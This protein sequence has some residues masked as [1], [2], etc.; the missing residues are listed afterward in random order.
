VT[1]PD[2]WRRIEE[3]FTAALDLPPQQQEAYLQAACGGDA[4]LR[5]EVESL[6]ERDNGD[7]DTKQSHLISGIIEGT[8]AN[9]FDD[10][11]PPDAMVG[12][13]LGNY[14]IIREL[15]RGGMGAVYL[16]GRFDSTF[17]KQVAIKLVKRGIDTD[18]VLQ[19]F[20]YER[21]I[22]AGLEHPYIAR[23]VD[24]GTSSDGRPYFV[25]EYVDGMPLDAYV[26]A[27]ALSLAARCELF[28]KICEAVSYAHRNLI[29]HRDLK[30]AN[31]LVTADGTPKL[32]DFGI[33]RLLS[34]DPD[35]HTIAGPAGIH[36]LA[37]TPDFAS[38]EQVRGEA[39]TTATDV[40][41]LGAVLRAMLPTDAAIPHD[42]TTI[43]G[44]AMREE[45]DQRF[46]SVADLSED[47]RR[48]LAG[49]PI[50]AREQTLAYSAA[51]FI[52]RHR[53]AVG[54]FA[55][56]NLL[57]FGGIAGIVWESRR[58]DA[59]RREAEQRLSQAVEMADRTLKDVNSS[60]AS[61]PGTTEARRQM[62]RSTLEYLDGLAKDS[63]NDPRVQIALAT[64]YVRVGE[65][66]GNSDFPNL[67][68]LPQSLAT[69]HRAL[70]VI[71]P[72]V[73]TDAGN[74]RVQLLASQAHQGTAD[75][76]V[77][78]GRDNDA[79]VEFR[80]AISSADQALQQSP[81]DPELQYQSLGA[82]YAFDLH[83]YSSH[84]E[85]AEK[86]A[87]Q[88]LPLAEKLAAAQPA[89]LD[90]QDK[91]SEFYA[92]I[93]TTLNRFNRIDEALTYYR[94]ASTVREAIYRQ[95]PRNTRLQRNLMIGYGHI[96]D[97]LGNPFTGCLADY[98][99]G[100]EYFLK[101]AAIAE[102]MHRAD[103]SDRRAS[104]DT[105][106]V[107]T[108]IGAT[109]SAAGS[110][111]QSNQY[112]DRAIALFETLM[113]RSPGNAGY[114]RGVSLAYDFRAQNLWTQRDTRAALVWYRKSLAM[115]DRVLAISSS[116]LSARGQRMA[117]EG[118]VAT[119][120]AE[121]G[122]RAGAIQMVEGLVKE[123]EPLQDYRR[124]LHLARAWGWYGRVYET[125]HDYRLAEIGYAKSSEAWNRV[126]GVSS[127]PPY[128]AQLQEMTRKAAQYR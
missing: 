86:D 101:A 55:L 24:G 54:V 43:V 3:V 106:M 115:A 100:L 91:L 34:V 22:L 9:L 4:D 18:A 48:Y 69:Y 37:L 15:G 102:D 109:Q 121:T 23:L 93:G 68:D 53:F 17:D 5:L 125:L 56:A 16:A 66:L 85:E 14:R 95:N 78:M 31:V 32:L 51:K 124:E 25:M 38:P 127:V 122:D 57:V 116:D 67:G 20:W 35:E 21:R 1:P 45:V 107:W 72:L 96:G 65:V 62:V 13:E 123:A 73:I 128:L 114:L 10:E 28:R 84:P 11:S 33:A 110:L 112:L 59:Q 80:T 97:V 36:A 79:A 89:N 44:K 12:A 90:R 58:A 70:A 82:H 108:R 42:L 98:S 113:A 111:P 41:S 71:Q 99:G 50:L 26:R 88:Q 49:L 119:L 19:R 61:L 105:A 94:K 40:Y 6:L 77:S 2:R 29:I 81:D 87:R 126:P 92:I 118:P 39:I 60:I 46:A 104:F 76:L 74:V 120:L 7:A 30:P 75:I 83:R 52:R 27:Q 8:A 47:V 63:G 103:P 117:D 64:A